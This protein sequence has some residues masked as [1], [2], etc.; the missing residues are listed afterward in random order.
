M[1]ISPKQKVTYKDK[2]FIFDIIKY[3]LNNNQNK[4]TLALIDRYME[5]QKNIERGSIY[6]SLSYMRSRVVK[7][8]ELK[9]LNLQNSNLKDLISC[10]QYPDEVLFLKDSYKETY[11]NLILE[12]KNKDIFKEH[13]LPTT[14]KILLHGVTGNGKTSFARRIAKDLN[15]PFYEVNCSKLIDSKL[16]KSAENIHDIL[17][18]LKEPCILFADEIDSITLKRGNSKDTPEYDRTQNSFLINI[19]KL[20]ENVLF[21]G[22][23]NR[24]SEMDD[25][26]K[27]RFDLIHEMEEPS[28]I[29]KSDYIERL[30]KDKNIEILENDKKDICFSYNSFSDVKNKTIKLMKNK[31]FELINNKQNELRKEIF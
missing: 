21:I 1:E 31:V 26:A 13:N 29:E 18:Q 24:L 7:V 4:D 27:R 9:P 19:E 14:N 22:A 23:T 25:A 12:V 30:I 28:L 2:D 11:N 5:S 15:L 8:T 16:G 6:Q 3:T 20:S 10:Y 17:T